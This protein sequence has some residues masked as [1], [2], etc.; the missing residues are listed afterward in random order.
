[1]GY[2]FNNKQI[3]S[4]DITADYNLFGNNYGIVTKQN[5]CE[6]PNLTMKCYL[7]SSENCK[8]YIYV[9]KNL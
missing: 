3:Q 5:H 2:S 4:N 6:F 1:M 8:Y 7:N 9:Y